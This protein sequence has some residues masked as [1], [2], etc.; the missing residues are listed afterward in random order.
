M[1]RK[2]PA[3]MPLSANQLKL[4]V[5]HALGPPPEREEYNSPIITLEM[6]ESD[7]EHWLQ[8]RQAADKLSWW[9]ISSVI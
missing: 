2:N 5:A 6:S 4:H 1:S 3:A 7:A 9:H 8:V